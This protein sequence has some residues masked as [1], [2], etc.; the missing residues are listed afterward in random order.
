GWL[1]AGGLANRA[2]SQRARSSAVISA[3]A[4]LNRFIRP[5]LAH[6]TNQVSIGFLVAGEGF[7]FRV[8]AQ[9][10]PE[11]EGDYAEMADRDGTVAYLRFTD[12][13]FAGADAIEEVAHMI[14]AYVELNCLGRERLRKQLRSA[15]L[16]FAPRDVDPAVRS[17]E[18]DAVE[19][20]ARLGRPCLAAVDVVGR[21]THTAMADA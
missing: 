5:R 8:P 18:L 10:P 19:Q 11:A 2:A 3:R 4:R 21:R 15:G 12:G 7:L 17:L 1:T 6:F 14:V 16:D 9:F 20:L 13:R